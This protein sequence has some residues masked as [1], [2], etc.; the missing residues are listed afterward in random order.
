MIRRA[1][2]CHHGVSR[3]VDCCRIPPTKRS[4]RMTRSSILIAASLLTVSCQRSAIGASQSLVGAKT[5]PSA[6]ALSREIVIINRGHWG[7]VGP[8]TPGTLAFQLNPDDS[9]SIEHT[10]SDRDWK[11]VLVG[12][13]TVHLSKAS[14]QF[15]RQSAWRLRPAKLQGIQDEILP[16]GC[17]PLP[18]DS[19]PETVVNFIGDPPKSGQERAIGIVLL[20]SSDQCNSSQANQARALV[21]EILRFFPASKVAAEYD[22]EDRRWREGMHS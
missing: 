18:I 22:V 7:N 1:T 9:L 8:N 20:P 19:G 5:L 16:T 13:E 15:V 11:H 4:M 14:A 10:K 2:E 21:H 12:R 17:R 3:E 6:R